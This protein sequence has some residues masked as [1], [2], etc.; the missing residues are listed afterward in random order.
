MTNFLKR[1][2]HAI[3][4]RWKAI[5]CF[6]LLIMCNLFI[7]ILRMLYLKTHIKILY[8]T[9]KKYINSIIQYEKIE[10]TIMLGKHK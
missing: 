5:C 7:H 8:R 3:E 10:T 2:I 4:G 9:K 6:I 1:P